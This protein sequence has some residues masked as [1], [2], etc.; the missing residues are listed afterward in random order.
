MH[1]DQARLSQLLELLGLTEEPMGVFF[2]DNEPKDG[3][4]PKPLPLPTR[5]RENENAIEWHEIFGNFSC[6][7]GNI[8]RARRKHTRA[9]FSAEHF[10]CPGGAFWLGFMKPQTQAIIHYV[11]TGIPNAMEGEWYCS[12][13][14]TLSDV[15]DAIGPVP[16]PKPYCVVQPLDLFE[17][18][19]TPLLVQFFARPESLCGLHQLA[20]FVTDD[21]QV[22]ASP[23]GAACTG[24]F[25]LALALSFPG[26]KK[27]CGGRLGSLRTQI[28]QN[29]RIELHRALDPV[30]RHARPL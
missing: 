6:V 18:D 21:T 24:S 1:Y 13:A 14:T 10:G 29:R 26:R 15:F 4:T 28:L 17:A 22:V 20:F 19:E 9:W 16:V 12:S 5:E 3:F 7:M 23:W 8:W 11:S 2:T 25:N 27:G 30:L